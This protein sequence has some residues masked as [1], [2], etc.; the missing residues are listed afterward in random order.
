MIENVFLM[1]VAIAVETGGSMVV[2]VLL[3]ADANF[4]IGYEPAVGLATQDDE[5]CIAL[6]SLFTNVRRVHRL[7]GL[8]SR[9]TYL[10]LNVTG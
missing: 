3:D 8:P 9:S 5:H 10:S 6:A 2:K 1:A 7:L 4:E